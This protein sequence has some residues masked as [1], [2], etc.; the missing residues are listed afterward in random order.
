M[1]D[2]RSIV[3]HSILN[4]LKSLDIITVHLDLHKR[5]IGFSHNDK[6]L[7][8]AYDDVELSEYRLAS[9]VIPQNLYNFVPATFELINE[10]KRLWHKKSKRLLCQSSTVKEKMSNC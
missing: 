2:R 8:D 7:G 9:S 4:E 3:Y 1:N 6:Y 10:C 5:K